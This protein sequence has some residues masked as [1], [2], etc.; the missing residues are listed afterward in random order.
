MLD[1]WP[2][3]AYKLMLLAAPLIWGASF[4]VMKYSLDIMGP[5]MLVGI[6]FVVAGLLV[7][8]FFFPRVRANLNKKTITA[9]V[10]LGAVYFAAYWAQNVGLTDTTPGKNAFLTAAYVVMVPYLYW[11]LAKKSPNIYNIIAAI[12]CLAGIGFVSLDAALNMGFGDSMTLVGGF[13]FALHMAL[14]PYFARDYDIFTMSFLQFMVCGILGLAVGFAIEPLPSLAELAN[15][16][17]FWQMFYLAV[18]SSFLAS[19]C[20]NVGQTRVNPSQASLILSLEGVF[21]VLIS[22]VFYGEVLSVRVIIGFA[23]IFIAVIVSEVLSTKEI[24]WQ[25][26]AI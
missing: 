23:L 16:T 4:V 7:L 18:G 3:W 5:A 10:I 6:R 19:M 15:P 21:G 14:I 26:K 11:V 13:F 2:S 22:I 8:V 9:G 1:R 17:F 24:P 12:L 20:Q 25:R